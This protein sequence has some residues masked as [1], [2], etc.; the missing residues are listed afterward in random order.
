MGLKKDMIDLHG[1]GPSILDG[2]LVTITVSLVSLDIAM[3]LGMVGA[4]AKLYGFKLL[5]LFAQIYTTVI[6]GIPDLVL[7]L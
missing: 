2:T 6:R 1:Y 7:M 4:L 3:L 5:R